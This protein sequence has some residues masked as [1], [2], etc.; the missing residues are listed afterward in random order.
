MAIYK[1]AHTT[2][3]QHWKTHHTQ[4]QHKIT[5]TAITR[6]HNTKIQHQRNNTNMQIPKY[7]TRTHNK[8]QI[9]NTNTIM[10]NTY[11]YNMQ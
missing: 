11:I 9:Q 3:W 2:H 7:T 10:Y 5:Q 1:A 8:T 4:H 6:T